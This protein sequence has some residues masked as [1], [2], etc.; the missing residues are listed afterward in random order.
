M[1][2]IQPALD[3]L[4]IGKPE[5]AARLAVECLR[6]DP[7]WVPA[8]LVL[9]EAQLLMGDRSALATA[10]RCVALDPDNGAGYEVLARV[11][12][13]RL[14]PRLARSV[15]QSGLLAVPDCTAL[16][17]QLSELLRQSGEL[18]KAL[19]QAEAALAMDPQSYTAHAARAWALYE[20]GEPGRAAESLRRAL[21]LAPEDA[22]LLQFQGHLDLLTTDIDRALRSYRE[23]LRQDPHDM[24][25]RAGLLRAMRARS[26]PFRWLLRLRNAVELFARRHP[27]STLGIV[28]TVALVPILAWGK[29]GK[30]CLPL[31]ALLLLL[32]EQLA[33]LSLLLHPTDRHLLDRVEATAA[34][35]VPALAAGALGLSAA[36]QLEIAANL[37]ILAILSAVLARERLTLGEY[38]RR[39]DRCQ[40]L[41][42]LA[43]FGLLAAALAVGGLIRLLFLRA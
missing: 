41:A 40:R 43:P 42:L 1:N 31:L 29:S 19:L 22:T 2:R 24:D 6:E 10:R 34:A 20:L 4:R 33:N 28:A 7:D 38:W 13:A 25:A 5:Q 17:V 27:M 39:A 14:E 8:L 15:L 23:S 26:G 32:P 18:L 12:C 37:S 21:A 30:F 35:V 11:H 3:L 16:R 36:G 9:G